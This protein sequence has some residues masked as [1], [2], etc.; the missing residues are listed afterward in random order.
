MHTVWSASFCDTF[1]YMIFFHHFQLISFFVFVYM[2]VVICQIKCCRT[3]HNRMRMMV[4]FDNICL[5]LPFLLL[6]PIDAIQ[7]KM[8]LYE[9]IFGSVADLEKTYFSC[10]LF[11][12]KMKKRKFLHVLVIN[13]LDQTVCI[14]PLLETNLLHFVWTTCIFIVHLY[15]L[16]LLCIF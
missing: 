11:S 15:I 2:N 6:R 9:M 1:I 8:S 4:N 14:Y 13:S 5:F 3:N 16:R 7:Q 10:M 12:V